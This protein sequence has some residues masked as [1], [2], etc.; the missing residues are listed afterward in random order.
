M[1]YVLDSS[2][3]IVLG[4]YYPSAFPSLWKNLEELIGNGTLT[5]VREVWNELERY[6]AHTFVQEWAKQHKT[7]FAKPTNEELLAVRE[8]LAVPHF[9]TLLG[10]KQVLTGTPVADPFVIAAAKVKSG[11]VVTQEKEKTNA[12]KIPN[13]CRYFGIPCLDLE[14]FMTVQKWKF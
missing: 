14:S 1:I 10:T 6:N 7:L 4:H 12:A 2:S 5:S 13:V 8:I 9:Q 3:L 11:T